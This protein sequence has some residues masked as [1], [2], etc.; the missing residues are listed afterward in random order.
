MKTITILLSAILLSLIPARA[1]DA[2]EY[3]S[4][5]GDIKYNGNTYKLAWS[6]H[7]T[8][9]YYIQEYLPEGENFDN[10]KS[11]FTVSIHFSDFTARDLAGLKV[12]ELEKRKQTDL[13]CN[14]LAFEKNDTHMLEF[15]VS[16]MAEAKAEGREGLSVVELDLHYYTNIKINGRTGTMLLFYSGRAYG[17]DITAFIKA[18]PDNRVRLITEM[19]A[20]DIR[21]IFTKQV[22]GN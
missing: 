11:M 7:P 10:Y 1:Q 19:E 20:L 14:Y 2:V 9:D 5:G 21:P 18:I 17:D 22:S 3:Y 6:S 4:V 13:V 15:L 16:D 8:A 12:Q